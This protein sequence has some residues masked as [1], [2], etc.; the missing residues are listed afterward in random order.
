MNLRIN[1]LLPVV[2][3]GMGG[4]WAGQR[5]VQMG[6][7]AAVVAGVLSYSMSY[8]QRGFFKDFLQGVAIGLVAP[9]LFQKFFGAEAG[10][11]RLPGS[12]SPLITRDLA[13]RA[14][15]GDLGALSEIRNRLA[16]LAQ[17]AND[18]V[19]PQ[20]GQVIDLTWDGG[21][22]WTAAEAGTLHF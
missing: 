19:H 22:T 20:S 4:M 6:D 3:G 8:G 11:P 1:K 15:A 2:A 10:I 5:L 9:A 16:E 21:N 7:W 18:A 14:Q 12:G 13:Q 17:R